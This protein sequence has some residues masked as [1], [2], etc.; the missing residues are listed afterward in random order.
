MQIFQAEI[1]LHCTGIHIY[2]CMLI[3]SVLLYQLSVHFLH[4]QFITGNIFGRYI[5]Y[6][7]WLS[8]LGFLK[9]VYIYP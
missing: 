9:L 2:A 3:N 8:L 4:G 6:L 7:F 1:S 5:I